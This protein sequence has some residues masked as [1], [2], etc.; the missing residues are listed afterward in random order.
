MLNNF[1]ILYIFIVLEDLK[2]FVMFTGFSYC[3]F[4]VLVFLIEIIF[5]DIIYVMI[6]VMFFVN[7]VFYNYGV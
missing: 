3:L 7:L 2:I 4:L 6:I 5:I 1:N